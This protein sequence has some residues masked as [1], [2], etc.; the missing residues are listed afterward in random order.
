MTAVVMVALMAIAMDYMK[1]LTLVEVRELN[2]VE[3]MVASTGICLVV[4]MGEHWARLQVVKRDLKMAM[5]MAAMWEHA[6][7]EM[8]E[9]L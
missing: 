5:I 8:K 9:Y 3:V 1:G 4:K 6:M 2:L 7:A